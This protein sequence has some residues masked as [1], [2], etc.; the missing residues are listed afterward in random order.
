VWLLD[1][2]ELV[3]DA[4]RYMTQ[5]AYDTQGRIA[6]QQVQYQNTAACN[7]LIGMTADYSYTNDLLASVA[8][9]GGYEGFPA[10]GAPKTDWA[11]SILY[12]YD[13]NGR[14]AREELAVTSLAKTYTQKPDGA[15]RDE[16]NRMYTNMRVKRPI[17]NVQRVGDVCAMSGNAFLSNPIDLRPFY[18]L[19]PNLTMQLPNGVTRAVVTFTY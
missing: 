16:V 5:Y 14:V 6:R 18:A 4:T 13:G 12:T 2:E 8:L 7:H 9:K 3:I 10:E 11:A 1:R 19:S 15:L 17:E